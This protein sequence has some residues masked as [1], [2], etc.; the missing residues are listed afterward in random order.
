MLSRT[1]TSQPP[2]ILV[3][4][5]AKTVRALLREHLES[6]GYQIAEAVNGEDCLKSFQQ[7]RPDIV[8]LDAVMPGMDGFNCC[9]RLRRLPQGMDTPILMITGLDD[10]SSV[11]RAFA[12]GATD[13]ITKPIYW[14]VLRMRVS[15]LIEASRA[16]VKLRQQSARD[17]LLSRITQAIRQSLDIEQIFQ[18]TVAQLGAVFK[19]NHCLIYTWEAE[20]LRLVAEHLE[21]NC[22]EIPLPEQPL[23][24]AAFAQKV[25]DQDQA[26]AVAH[27]DSHPLLQSLSPRGL[28]SVMAVRTSYQGQTNGAI[29]LLQH[30]QPRSWRSGEVDVLEAVAAQVGI[31][32]AQAHLLEQETRQR[33]QLWQQNLALVAAKQAA[34]AAN[35]AKG[36]FLAVMSHEIRTP[37]NAVIGMTTLL[38]DTSLTHQQRDYVETIHGSGEALLCLINDI[39]DFSKIESGKLELETRPFNLRTCLE[40]A[41]DLLA[42]R[43]TEKGIELAYLI[44]PPTPEQIQGDVIRLRQILVNLINNAI[45]FTEAG[46]VVISVTA[47]EVLPLRSQLSGGEEPPFSVSAAYETLL[48]EMPQYEIQFAVEDTG[49]GI[50]IDRMDRLFRPFSQVDSSVRRQY[51]GTGLGLAIS[52]KLAET[53]GGR[54]WVSSRDETG[55]IG[56]AGDSPNGFTDV[57]LRQ[58]SIFYFTILVPALPQPPPPPPPPSLAGKRLLIVDDNPTYRKILSLYSQFWGTL[59]YTFAAG[60][61]A[62]RRLQQQPGFDLAI[63]D[64]RLADMDGLSLIEQIRQ[65]PQ[66]ATL[67]LIFL[68]NT[69]Q[70]ERMASHLQ[71]GLILTKP[72][73]QSQLQNALLK[74]LSAEPYATTPEN[75]PSSFPAL[76]SQN[77]LRILLAED[78]AV[79]QKVALHLLKRLGYGADVAKN[80]IQVLESL[81]QQSYDVI[82]MDV[83][84]PEM[85]GLTA[86]QQIR[87]SGLP[88]PRIIAMTANAVEG[89]REACLEA[90]MDDYV[91]KPIRLPDL[92]EALQKCRPLELNQQ[93]N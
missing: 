71:S 60:S 58:G 76:G 91:S 8:L 72:L 40:E 54:I 18:T 81:R 59:P 7:L 87:R 14:A 3:V 50:P 5:D 37:M 26:I 34:E 80:G 75:T 22:L 93:L 28:K 62:L 2:L 13:Y 31:A 57:L 92:V 33:E 55:A 38:L 19:V 23:L 79:N 15:R 32:L 48:Y 6:V 25:L 43:A 12:A 16:M 86:T 36:R 4:D 1:F 67:P 29:A 90:G 73:R 64:D 89:D 84:M 24:N 74:L 70:R 66:S 53:M 10:P 52:K 21:P 77:L 65:L 41:I 82:L 61:E 45:K 42:T 20:A 78:N 83:Q 51:G 46:E 35:Q 88:Q 69:S 44:S 39:L 68:T 49:I 56:R 63:I 85:D 17:R 30:T 47:R 27:V 11:E 9:A